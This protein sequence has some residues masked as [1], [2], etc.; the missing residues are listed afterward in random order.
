MPLWEEE[1]YNRLRFMVKT[2][3]PITGRIFIGAGQNRLTNMI[4]CYTLNK[5]VYESFHTHSGIQ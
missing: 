1:G 2:N 3:R 5:L 4:L